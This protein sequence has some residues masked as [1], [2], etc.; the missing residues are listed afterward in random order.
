MYAG[1]MARRFGIMLLVVLLA[2]SINFMLP[3]LMPG[4][5]IEAQLNQLIATGGGAVG[6]I[7]AMAET[8]RARFGLDQPLW[9]Q[10]IAYWQLLLRFD[11]GISLAS[12]PETVSEAIWAGLPWTLG[13][14]GFATLASFAIG[15]L[16]GGLMAWPRAPNGVKVLGSGLV[17]L[18]SVPYFLVGM[19][20][21]YV[22]A[23]VL[24]WFPA[25]G[26]LP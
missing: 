18:S 23:I 14:I 9:S 22:F 19:I 2:V 11:L 15:S 3:R 24:R 26:G 4:D 25:G 12:Y 5:P 7:V 6:D 21:L 13:L 8:Y 17:L 1:Y 16:L 20:L 10:Y